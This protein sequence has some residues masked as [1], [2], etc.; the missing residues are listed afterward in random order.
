[1]LLHEHAAEVAA[2]TAPTCRVWF[3]CTPPIA[4]SVSQPFAS[5][6]A[7][8]YRAWALSSSMRARVAVPASPRSRPPPR[9]S[10]RRSSRCTGDCPKSSGTRSKRSIPIS[11]ILRSCRGASRTA[12]ATTL[13]SSSIERSI[14]SCGTSRPRT[15]RGSGRGQDLVLEEDLLDHLLR[16]A[17]EVRAAQRR[18]CVVVGARPRRP[19]ALPADRVHRRRVRERLVERLLRRVRD[20]AVRVDA[21]RAAARAGLRAARRCSSANGVKRSGSP[22]MIAS[23]IGRPSTPRAPRTRAAADRDPHGQRILHRPRVAPRERLREAPDVAECSSS[24]A[25]RR[26]ARRSLRSKPKSGNDSMN[27]PRPP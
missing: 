8:R 19:A 4:T 20:V 9:C 18:G 11:P 22:P 24:A 1:M 14:P 17:D 21:E 26:T 2:A 23:A 10:L 12:G 13:P 27:E 15:A 25:S 16:A 3:D 6:S 5:A 7:T